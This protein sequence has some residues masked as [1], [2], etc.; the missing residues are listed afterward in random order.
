MYE[1]SPWHAVNVLEDTIM[2]DH[3][4]KLKLSLEYDIPLEIK[5]QANEKKEE[6]GFLKRMIHKIDEKLLQN[7]K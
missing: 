3:P 4:D 1:G 5:I 2:F 7:K 6:R